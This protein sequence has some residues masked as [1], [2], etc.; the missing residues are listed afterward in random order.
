MTTAAPMRTGSSGDRHGRARSIEPRAPSTWRRTTARGECAGD[1]PVLSAGLGERPHRRVERGGAPQQIEQPPAGVQSAP[2][3]VVRAGDE[4]VGV[5]GVRQQQGHHAADQQVEGGGSAASPDRQPNDHAAEEQVAQRVGDRGQL[6]A[7]REVGVR[8]VRR[9]QEDPRQHADPDRDHEGVDQGRPVA[10]GVAA[11]HQDDQSG[12]EEWVDGEVQR[13]ADR[14]E[15]RLGV[16]DALVVV[17]D[18]VARDEQ[19]EADA[20]QVP[21]DRHPGPVQSDADEDGHCRRATDDIHHRPRSHERGPRKYRR[22]R[23]IPPAR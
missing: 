15:R 7:Q 18:D 4:D 6:L 9:H 5:L 12:D 21:G 16:E 20:E 19:H 23:A 17:R 14:W 2:G 11:A 22:P 8:G 10:A 3:P 1:G 13:V